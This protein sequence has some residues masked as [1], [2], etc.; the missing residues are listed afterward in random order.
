LLS[1]DVERLVVGHDEECVWRYSRNNVDRVESGE[2]QE[3][4]RDALIEHRARR[5]GDI[6]E[7][8]GDSFEI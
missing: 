6:K 7:I 5:G 8:D 3:R 1:T 2:D 4:L